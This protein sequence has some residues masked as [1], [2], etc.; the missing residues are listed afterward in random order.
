[1]TPGPGTS[2][3]PPPGAGR[4]GAPE[5][6]PRG[7]PGFALVSQRLLPSALSLLQLPLGTCPPRGT[8]GAGGQPLVS[9]R[10]IALSP[11]GVCAWDVA[12]RAFLAK[13][14]FLLS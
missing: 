7:K 2:R 13:S 1:M 5:G 4:A 3:D 11:A 10:P 6:R 9:V 8:G 12:L 14:V